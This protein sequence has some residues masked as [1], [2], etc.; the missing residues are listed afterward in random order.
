LSSLL[1]ETF[2]ARNFVDAMFREDFL[3][4]AARVARE[5]GLDDAEQAAVVAM[6]R[7]GL[8]LAAQ[9]FAAKRRD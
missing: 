8:R 7:P 6:D 5:F 2:L 9:S 3:Q 1:L 4:D